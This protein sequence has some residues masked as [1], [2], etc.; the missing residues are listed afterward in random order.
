MVY[1]ADGSVMYSCEDGNAMYLCEDWKI[2][3]WCIRV[4]TGRYGNCGEFV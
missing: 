4:K 2:D 3:V 1:S